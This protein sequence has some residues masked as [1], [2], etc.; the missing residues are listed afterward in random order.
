M[1]QLPD[2]VGMDFCAPYFTLGDART[3]PGTVI[4]L[5]LMPILNGSLDKLV[6]VVS[7]FR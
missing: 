7:G 2:L 3:R 1:S 5:G 6:Q 4:S